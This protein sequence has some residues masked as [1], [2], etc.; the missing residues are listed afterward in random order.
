MFSGCTVPPDGR[1][2]KLGSNDLDTSPSAGKNARVFLCHVTHEVCHYSY[3]QW[4]GYFR[5]PWV[6]LFTI[7]EFSVR[8]TKITSRNG[9]SWTQRWKGFRFWT[10]LLKGRKRDNFESHNFL[11]LSFSNIWGLCSNFVECESFL[12]SNSP[13]SF[14]LYKTNLDDSINSGNF[15]VRSY[16]PLIQKDSITHMHGLAVYVE[17]GLNSAD[18]YFCFR[19]A[20]LHSLSYFFLYRSPSLSLCTIFDVISSYIDGFSRSTLLPMCLS[21]KT[22]MSIIRVG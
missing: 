8:V 5:G 9:V 1:E 7:D 12:E 10:T 18:S 19:L 14:A 17:V 2:T 3:F 4:C 16:L 6:S 13:D 21:L 15:S 20:L 22:L 11:K